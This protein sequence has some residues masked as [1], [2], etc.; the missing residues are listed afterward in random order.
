MERRMVR[1]ITSAIAAGGVAFGGAV[2]AAFAN[3]GQQISKATYWVILGAVIGAIAKD[4]Q[5]SLSSPP[6][7]GGN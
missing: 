5:A 7:Q 4:I 2:S 1:V 3:G 6:G